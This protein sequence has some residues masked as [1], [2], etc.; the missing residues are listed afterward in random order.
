MSAAMS[1]MV[2]TE[3]A[4]VRE[5]RPNDTS[6]LGGGSSVQPSGLAGTC[7]HDIDDR[8]VRSCRSAVPARKPR[9]LP[10]CMW[11]RRQRYRNR[12]CGDLGLGKCSHP[13]R[14]RPTLRLAARLLMVR[15]WKRNSVHIRAAA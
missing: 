1:P 14:C 12:L 6:V 3:G 2:G 11:H 7:N 5:P 13:H 9:G 15:P 10:W 4:E 8:G